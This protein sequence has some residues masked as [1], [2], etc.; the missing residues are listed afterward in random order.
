LV[1]YLVRLGWSHGDQEIFTRQELISYF[2]LDHVGKKSAIFDQEKLDWINGVYMRNTDNQVLLDTILVSIKSDFLDQLK[3]WGKEKILILIDLY[4]QR[5]KTLRELVD[6]LLRF[7][8]I[9]HQY[10]QDAIKKWIIPESIK[11]LKFLIERLECQDDFS[12]EGFS[13][14]I[15][16]VC[17]EL[18]IKLVKLAQPIRIALTGSSASPG[19]FEL[20]SVIGKEE[21]IARLKTF[22]A[23]LEKSAVN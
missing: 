20:L 15:H 4:K 10:D 5:T 18:S 13:S 22:V 17:N 7:Y 14:V 12:V 3:K 16:A 9:P 11:Y 19:I 1:N 21:S 8:K 23:F 6:E 2:T